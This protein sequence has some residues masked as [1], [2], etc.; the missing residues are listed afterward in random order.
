MVELSTRFLEE[1]LD[2]LIDLRAERDWWKDEPRCGYAQRY[3]DL[4]K[5][6]NMLNDVLVKKREGDEPQT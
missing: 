1:I 2:D 6:I 5:R 3:A 4:S